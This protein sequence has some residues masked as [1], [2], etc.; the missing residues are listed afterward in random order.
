MAACA[1][2]FAVGALV[3]HGAQE[4]GPCTQNDKLRNEANKLFCN[5]GTVAWLIAGA[6]SPRRKTVVSFFSLKHS[7]HSRAGSSGSNY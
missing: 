1:V 6:Y 5:R 2:H 3:G 4:N 7:V